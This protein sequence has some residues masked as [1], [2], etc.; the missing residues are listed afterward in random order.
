MGDL[1]WMRGRDL[2][3]L[4][5]VNSIY[6]ASKGLFEPGRRDQPNAAEIERQV[7]MPSETEKKHGPAE[8]SRRARSS[9]FQKLVVKGIASEGQGGC[10][11]PE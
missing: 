5:A 2:T 10:D 1:Y 8:M 6:L 7:R 11:L 4:M 9:D 3:N